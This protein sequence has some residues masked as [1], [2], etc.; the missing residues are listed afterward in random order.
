MTRFEILDVIQELRATGA[1]FCVATV[2]RTADL[3]SAKA[4]AKAVLTAEGEIMGHLGGGCVRGAV[5]RAASEVLSTGAARM[6]SVRPSREAAGSEPD[7]EVHKSGCPSGG[8]V[9]VFIEPYLLPLYLAVIG[10][11]PIARAVAA[12]GAL[13]GYAITQG[14]AA[15]AAMDA[16]AIVVAS[17]GTGDLDAL[18]AALAS[19]ASYIAMVASHRKADALRDRL[20][21]EGVSKERLADLVSPAGLDLRAIDPHEIAVSII[22]QLIAW[23]RRKG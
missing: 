13:M 12:H 1:P 4:G 20:A 18:R 22:A 14:L 8:T 11:T 3:T 17:Q 9:D 15:D 10:D 21:A 7:I 19:P 23:R 16:D 2:V 6:I 5:T